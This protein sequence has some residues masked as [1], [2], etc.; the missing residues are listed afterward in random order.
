LS[1]T[2]AAELAATETSVRDVLRALSLPP[3]F[4][5]NAGAV[6]ASA[7]SRVV[8]APLIIEYG[9]TSRLTLGVAIPIVETRTTVNAQLN[10]IRPLTANV[11]P[12]PAILSGDYTGNNTLVTSFRAA[13]TALSRRLTDCQ[14]APTSAGC[15]QVIA[16]QAAIQSLLQ[17]TQ[18][19]TTGVEQ[20]YGTG[21]EHPGRVFVPQATS[22]AQNA[23]NRQIDRL[24]QQY[25]AFGATVPSGGVGAPFG[26]GARNDLQRLL[27]S[28]GYDTLRSTDHSSF[29]DIT[30]GATLQLANTFGDTTGPSTRNYRFAVNVAGRIGTGQPALP[31]RLFDNAT[32][33]GTFGVIVGAAGDFQI[34]RRFM[35]SATGS[36]TKQLGS[37][38]VVRVPNVANNALPLTTPFVGDYRAG[39]V[40]TLAVVP[41][42]RLARFF[43]I[44][45]NYSL[46]RVGADDY[47]IF[48]PPSVVVPPAGA[49]PVVAPIGPYGMA[50]ATSHQLGFGFSYSTL[51]SG[52]RGPGRLPFEVSFRHLETLAA[53][54]GPAPKTSQE[55]VQL[56]VFFR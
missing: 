26:P 18:A 23:I 15:S 31:N 53:S 13:A 9:L 40:V 24:K 2:H 12:N 10:R 46:M 37:V 35:T 14:A 16:Q 33:Y 55:Q 39:D 25:S 3:T 30:I 27:T 47:G 38:D 17:T 32:G 42:Y 41:R 45:G 36:Y 6:V 28:A 20:L 29:G 50:A 1:G 7:N 44:D 19:F 8:T 52:D 4:A 5:I 21:T 22:D 43:S 51:A 48:I 34:S 49:P 11:G 54:G 56:R